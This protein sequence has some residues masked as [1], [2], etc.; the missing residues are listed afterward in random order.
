[1]IFK[2]FCRIILKG[3]DDW[4]NGNT[5]LYECDNKECVDPELLCNGVN[6]CSDGTDEAGC[7]NKR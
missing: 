2:A 5:D 7:N 6:D 3:G 1:M 4:C